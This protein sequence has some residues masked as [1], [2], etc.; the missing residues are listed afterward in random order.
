M[1]GSNGELLMQIKSRIDGIENIARELK[2]L[3]IGVA[4]IEKNARCMS[5]FTRALQFAISD[6]ADVEDL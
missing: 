4:V 1:T 5:S 6:I 2:A 3:G